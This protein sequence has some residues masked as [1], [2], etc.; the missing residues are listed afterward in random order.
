LIFFIGPVSGVRPNCCHFPSV[1]DFATFPTLPAPSSARRIGSRRGRVPSS[2]TGNG[3]NGVACLGTRLRKELRCLCCSCLPGVRAIGWDRGAGCLLQEVTEATEWRVWAPG[4]RRNSV[5]SVASCL[6]GVRAIGRARGALAAF[7]RRQ[8]RQRS[9]VF[10]GTRLRKELRCLCC[11]LFTCLESP[12][13]PF[14][15]CFGR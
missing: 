8:R 9:R 5:A 14:P 13:L 1:I 3:G 7:Y 10:G 12:S 15:G 11:L 4:S 2:R 6:P